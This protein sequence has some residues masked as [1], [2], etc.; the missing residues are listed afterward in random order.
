[1]SD[2]GSAWQRFRSR[3]YDTVI[4]AMTSMWYREVLTLLPLRTRLLDVGIGN[5]TSLINNR[6]VVI[7]KQ[8]DVTGVDYDQG[9]IDAANAAVGLNPKLRDRVHLVCASIHDYTGGPFDA[10]YFSGSFMIIPD[11]VNALRRCVTML[12]PRLVTPGES[13]SS[14]DPLSPTKRYIYFTQTFEKKRRFLLLRVLDTI[15][16]RLKP[17]LKFLTTID[18]GQVTY[19][20]DF[21]DVIRA[22]GLAIEEKRVLRAGWF[23]DQVLVVVSA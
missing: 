2:R 5:A 21:R 19:E 10:I 22:A 12:A 17:L 11:K 1:M 14:R 15:L 9:Y 16:Q 20:E 13:K 3:V 23:R 7:S 18:F 8:L 4:V 6:D